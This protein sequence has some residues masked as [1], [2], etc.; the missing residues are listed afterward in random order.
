MRKAWIIPVAALVVAL[1]FLF[2]RHGDASRWSSGDPVLVII[3]PHNEAIRYE[4]GR[5]FSDWHEQRYGKPV[6]VDWRVIGGTAEIMRYLAAEYISSF[7]AWWK[8]EGGDWPDGGGNL[9]LD[10]KFNPDA[11][12]GD[13]SAA[14]RWKR[15]RDIH[16]AM[17]SFDD[18]ATFNCGID[19]FYGGGT[20]DH[21]KA[22]GQGLTVPPWSAAGMPDTLVESR[23]GL[24]L[25]PS[26]LGG[27]TWRTATF[28][29][30]ALSTFGICFNSD[31]LVD[32]GVTNSPTH[33]RDLA[34]PA[35]IGQLGIADPTKSGSIAKAFE[36]IVHQQCYESIRAAGFSDAQI[37]EFESDIRGAGLGPGDLPDGVPRT[38]QD[39]VEDG[40]M[41]GIRLVQRISA[42]A[43]YFTDSASKVPIDVSMGSAAAG[44]AID[45]YGRYQAE[46]SRAP[47]GRHRMTYVTPAGGSSVSADPISLLRGAPN[48]ELAVRFIEF[49]LGEDGQRLWNYAVG[50][51]GG[52]RR[53]A[54]RRLPVRRDFYPSDDSA[55]HDVHQD[56][57]RHFVDD[58][59][60]DTINP[61]RIAAQFTYRS[62]WTAGHFDAHRKLIR[63]MSMD[64]GLELRSA[65]RAIIESGGPD[66]QPGALAA[67]QRMPSRPEPMNWVTVQSVAKRYDE[68]EYMREWTVFFRNSYKEAE[69]IARSGSKAS[70]RF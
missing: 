19:L 70:S 59:G 18:P 37:D 63:A 39:A 5:G 32:L 46:M 36:M 25:M 64:A 21:G 60:D 29:G 17:R 31:R 45:F 10:R 44:I 62:R 24:V 43:R 41:R 28:F 57:A 7:R 49:V 67:L 55:I 12:P 65:W 14:A 20:Y 42:N 2:R 51:P 53:F 9:I 15:Q 35:F 8:R 1:P 16:A 58:L 40:W 23:H 38:Y 61:Y 4:F 26:R 50:T 52:P 6:K 48:R 68:L 3:S 66:A 13:A 56:H 34:N 69:R 27:E 22:G 30:A 11:P 54:L 33:W 47:D